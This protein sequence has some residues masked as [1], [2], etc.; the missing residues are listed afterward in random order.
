M[1]SK[2]PSNELKSVLSKVTNKQP[3]RWLA[4]ATVVL[5]TGRHGSDVALGRADS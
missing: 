2:V 3:K 1:L 4:V 5:R